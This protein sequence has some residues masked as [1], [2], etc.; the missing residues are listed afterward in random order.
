MM[1]DNCSSSVIK[2]PLTYPARCT[3]LP[4]DRSIPSGLYFPFCIIHF[5]FKARRAHNFP[6]GKIK[7][8][9]SFV[10]QKGIAPHTVALHLTFKICAPP[11]CGKPFVCGELLSHEKRSF[12]NPAHSLKSTRAGSH[13]P[14]L[15]FR[16]GLRL[17]TIGVSIFTPTVFAPDSIA[18]RTK[19]LTFAD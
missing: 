4:F 6:P 8:K 19:S 13:Y 3:I 14:P 18:H 2:V 10:A 17:L 16:P 7:L 12:K 11:L 5:L 9:S 15:L 1:S